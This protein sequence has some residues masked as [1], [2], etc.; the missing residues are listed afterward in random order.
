MS[1][2]SSSS[3][4]LLSIKNTSREF[5]SERFS[6]SSSNKTQR[7]IKKEDASKMIIGCD[8]GNV[9]RDNMSGKSIEGAIE[10]IK[11]LL[12][13]NEVVLISKCKE[14]YKQKSL[15]FLKR[16]GLNSIRKIFVTE[17]LDKI[18]VPIDLDVMIDDKIKI[19]LA[20]PDSV[21]KIWFCR[22]SKKIKGAKK[23]NPEWFDK[24]TLCQNWHG[25]LATFS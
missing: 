5:T 7:R 1:S 10:G 4:Q 21:Q 24:V 13:S 3:Q 15:N 17:D 2:S 16:N 18:T 20:Y 8:I 22:D 25:I 6:H 9:L 12:K 23:Y 14:T 11:L 19:L